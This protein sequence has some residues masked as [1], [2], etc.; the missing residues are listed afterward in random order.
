MSCQ[1]YLSLAG[2]NMTNIQHWMRKMFWNVPVIK[3]S[4]AYVYSCTAARRSVYSL[5]LYTIEMNENSHCI[6]VVKVVRTPIIHTQ[7]L[8][9]CETLVGN[10]R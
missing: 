5:Q 6:S 4:T 10:I 3:V 7:F 9:V 8:I 2:L 1:A